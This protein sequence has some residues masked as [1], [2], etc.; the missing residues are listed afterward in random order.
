MLRRQPEVAVADLV[1]ALDQARR[2]PSSAAFQARDATIAGR[3]MRCVA[4][5]EQT[6]LTYHVTLPDRA[7][8]HA[9]VGVAPETWTSPQSDVQFMVGVSD[10]RRYRQL[11]EVTL[12]PF[13]RLPDRQWRQLV[14]NLRE[15]AGLT[16]DIVLNTRA[17]TS[18]ESDART[19]IA[20]WGNPAVIAD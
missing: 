13:G 14:V 6:R 2:Q 20:L 18:F 17:G 5:G 9:M 7:W 16:V 3:T 19:D 4:A 8:F 12:D 15:Y 10:G 11:G 1:T